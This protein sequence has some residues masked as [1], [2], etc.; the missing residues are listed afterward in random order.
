MDLIIKIN[1]DDDLYE[2]DLEKVFEQIQWHL[3]RRGS[4]LKNFGITA[5]DGK[6]LGTV[7]V[8]NAIN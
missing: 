5:A 8:N 2:S 7:E 4:W 1:L 3:E 6:T